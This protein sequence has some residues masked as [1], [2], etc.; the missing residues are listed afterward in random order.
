[1]KQLIDI[2]EP[3]NRKKGFYRIHPQTARKFHE[4]YHY[5]QIKDKCRKV[6]IGR[7]SSLTNSADYDHTTKEQYSTRLS[8]DKAMIVACFLA[9]VISYPTVMYSVFV[10]KA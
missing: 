1:M 8:F 5:R 3:K 10:N 7:A 6:N 4:A 2:T 9:I